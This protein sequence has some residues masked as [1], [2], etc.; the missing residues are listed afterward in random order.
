[1]APN[2]VI[3]GGGPAGLST[4]HK[5]LKLTTPKAKESKITLVSESAHLYWNI[6]SVRAVLPD[7]IPDDQLFRPISEGFTQYPASRF[8]LIVGKATGVTFAQ[9]TVT[10]QTSSGIQSISYD[11][12]VL[13]TGASLPHGLPFKHV[14]TTDETTTALH[15]LQD[16][17]KKAKSIVIA[18]SGPTGIETMGELGHAY[19]GS[20]KL[21]LVIS[22]DRALSNLMPSVGKA[23]ENELTKMKVDLIHNA[24]V[25]ASNKEG[26]STSISL[27]TGKTLTA[28]LYIPLFGVIPNTSFLPGDILDDSGNVKLDLS[29]RVSGQKN[30]WGVGDI[31]NLESK[32]ATKVDPQVKQ[33]VQNLEAV[34]AGNAGGVVDY[35][36]SEKPMIGI[37]IGKSK[38]TGQM[39][40]MKMFSWLIWLLKGRTLLVEK[41]GSTVMGQ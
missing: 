37:T 26:D 11:Q 6:A 20:K 13:A 12:L 8:E 19:G 41:A 32:Q 21:T 14:G 34:V 4:A 5:L 24:S 23:A 39:G 29:L 36:P 27:S 31:G 16:K 2:I 7:Q 40:G 15:D 1:M 3:L 9:N 17:I 35:V 10:V 22:S 28:D 25:V 33:L 18:G 38:G 30:V